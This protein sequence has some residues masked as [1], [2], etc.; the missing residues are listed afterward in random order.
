MSETGC[1]FSLGN[2]GKAQAM[3]EMVP[4]LI[5]KKKVK[6]KDLPTEVFI[7]KK[8]QCFFFFQLFIISS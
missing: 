2:P 8:R 5:E 6:G 4:H 3:L 1:H 7:K